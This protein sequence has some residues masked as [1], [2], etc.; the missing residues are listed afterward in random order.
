[1]L[2][3][4]SGDDSL[5]ETAMNYVTAQLAGWGPMRSAARASL[6]NMIGSWA[7]ELLG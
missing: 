5:L 4:A 7:L 3:E 1:M 6:F 2:C